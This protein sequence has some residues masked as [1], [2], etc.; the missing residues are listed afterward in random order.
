M[1]K[2][3]ILAVVL[4]VIMCLTAFC[5]CAKDTGESK[6]NKNEVV[7]R[8][9]TSWEESWWDPAL[10][11]SVSDAYLSANIYENLFELQS[12]G[13]LKPQLAEKWEVSDDG[14]TY[15]FKL[16]EN[17]KWH[18]GYGEF[19]SEDVKFT[20]ERQSDP[21]VASVNAE[22][23][24]V[25]NIESIDCPDKYTVVLKLKQPDVDLLTRLALYYGI[26]V[27]K[28]HSDKDG[29][30]SINTDPIGTGPFVFDG[31]TLGIK[32]EAV[33]NKDWW[34]NF[35]GNVDRVIC[36]FIGDTNTGYT[37]FDNRELDILG[38]FDKDKIREYQEKGYNVKPNPL[39][40][41]LYIGVNMQL[42]PFNDP[43]VR[44]AL[45]YAI[46]SEYFLEDFFYGEESA[47]GSYLP[48]NTKYAV[49]DYFKPEFSIE[50][51][52]QLLARAGYPDGLEITMWG[53]NDALGQPP[54][55]IAQDML[56]NA[57]FKVNLQS[58][59]FGVWIDKIRNGQAPC[60]VAYNTTGTIGD[61]TIIRYTSQYYPRNNWCGVLDEEY[62]ALVAAGQAATTEKEKMEYYHAAQKRMMD[63]QVI[64]PVSTF[65]VGSVMQNNVSG[66]ESWGDQAFRAHTITV[67]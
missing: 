57:G 17:V 22:N 30:S 21:A 53:A 28:A 31:G 44:E 36:T 7:L 51:A 27:C 52:K 61:D 26:I 10:F 32:T 6:D 14:R 1:K 37:A 39:L 43:L 59:D 33:R 5:A 20:L 13:T 12:D 50:K 54:S 65:T 16:R 25:A 24:H 42:E 15:T 47:V 34:G 4:A 64:Y 41:L 8:V 46:D 29:V 35:T 48:P 49:R 40:Q 63:L 38:I 67:G 23:L 56:S 66:L 62:D 2:K 55:I 11:M 9:T 45:F 18:K 60:W 19:T 3:R 58:V